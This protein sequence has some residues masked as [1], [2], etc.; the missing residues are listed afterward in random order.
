[1]DPTYTVLDYFNSVYYPTCDPANACQIYFCKKNNIN[2]NSC[3]IVDFWIT[4][5]SD[6]N[7]YSFQPVNK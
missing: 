6:G 5:T 1:M 7:D 2:T 3:P 4:H